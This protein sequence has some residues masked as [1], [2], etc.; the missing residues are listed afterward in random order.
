M[1]EEPKHCGNIEFSASLPARLRKPR[2]R[3]W[4]ASE[5]LR[6]VHGIEIA[7]TTLAKYATV[8]GGPAFQRLN[9]TPLYPTSNLDEWALSKLGRLR[10][11]SSEAGL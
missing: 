11:S 4:E 2:L 8:G 5:Y 10:S 1:G 3:R 7:S 6:L 9:R